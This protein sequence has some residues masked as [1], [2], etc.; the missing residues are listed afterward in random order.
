MYSCG[1]VRQESPHSPWLFLG[2]DI[3]CPGLGPHLALA[4]QQKLSAVIL[5]RPGMQ[6]YMAKR[7]RGRK[8][9]GAQTKDLRAGEVWVQRAVK[10]ARS[11]KGR[12]RGQEQLKFL[13]EGAKRNVSR[14]KEQIKDLRNREELKEGKEN[15]GT[16]LVEGDI[17]M[18]K[19][20]E[21]IIPGQVIQL[22]VQDRK[23]T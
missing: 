20:H 4:Q 5:Q 10:A 7:E 19:R 15:T 2:S 16:N 1:R 3:L 21:Q 9:Q 22:E 23:I 14:G 11:F 6:R 13:A 18:A 8:S 17:L 12:H